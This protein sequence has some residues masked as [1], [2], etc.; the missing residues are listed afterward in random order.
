MKKH[1]RQQFSMIVFAVKLEMPFGVPNFAS[2]DW[3][4]SGYLDVLRSG[5]KVE[6]RNFTRFCS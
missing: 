6:S 2:C 3:M 1:Y 5:N 4:V